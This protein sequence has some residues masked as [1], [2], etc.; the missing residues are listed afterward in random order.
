MSA[1]AK[2]YD[3]IVA[4]AGSAGCAL[5]ARLA[6][7][8]D[9]RV[10]LV[11]AGGNG[12][13]LF[14][15]MP[16]GNGFLFGNPKYDWGSQSAPQPGLNGRRIYYPRGK[17]LGGTSLLNGMIYIRGNARDYD[18]WRQS[19]LEGWGYADLLPYF[20]RAEAT[21]HRD[22]PYHGRTGPLRTSPTGN[23]CEIDRMFIA[24]ACQ[25]GGRENPD[26]NGAQQSGAGRF[27]ATVH[28]GSR[29][30][31][32]RAYLARPPRNL[33]IRTGARITSVVLE[34]SR[35]VGLRMIDGDGEQ[36]VRAACEVILSLGAFGS[37]QVL[38][39]SGIGPA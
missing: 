16:A 36:V 38:M 8:P 33:T 7:D 31:V 12:R 17:G 32:A 39:L 37:P 9:A 27:D 5:A 13:S 23:Y 22:D 26:F 35:A 28:H 34:G 3:Y 25:A 29:Q 18:R 6:E 4:G 30:S 24:A 11:E 19:G 14:V 1:P 21:P 20:R 15:T 2:E 10:L